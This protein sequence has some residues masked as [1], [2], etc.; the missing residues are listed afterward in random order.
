MS[1]VELSSKRVLQCKQTEKNRLSQFR[2][3]KI[4]A[5][6]GRHQ[7]NTLLNIFWF[8]LW[9]VKCRPFVYFKNSKHV[10]IS[11]KQRVFFSLK[12]YKIQ[13][14]YLNG[15]RTSYIVNTKYR[16]QKNIQSLFSKT[17][18]LTTI[19]GNLVCRLIYSSQRLI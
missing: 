10:F 17:V 7:V 18:W 8:I 5:Y 16:A 19:L 11:D 15:L 9:W 14:K 4:Q 6:H 3:H 13:T 2:S 1:W 12:I